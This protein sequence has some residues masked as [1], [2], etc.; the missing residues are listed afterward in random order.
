MVCL[1]YPQVLLSCKH[2]IIPGSARDLVPVSLVAKLRE[3]LS[4]EEKEVCKNISELNSLSVWFA[5]FC[6]KLDYSPAVIHDE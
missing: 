6:N 3:D 5:S 4:E 2:Y 1:D